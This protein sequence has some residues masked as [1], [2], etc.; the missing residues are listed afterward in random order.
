MKT[1]KYESKWGYVTVVLCMLI[2]LHAIPA[3]AE[4]SSSITTLH[5]FNGS[6]GKLPGDYGGGLTVDQGVLYGT[7]FLGGLNDAGVVFKINPDGSGFSILHTFA[8]TGVANDGSYPEDCRLAVGGGY[9]YGMTSAGGE[10]GS[11][12]IYKMRTDGSEYAVLK[13]FDSSGAAGGSPY[14]ALTLSGDVLYGMTNEGGENGAG[15]LFRIGTDGSDF[16]VLRSFVEQADGAGPH[17][18]VLVYNNALYGMNNYG[19]AESYGTIFKLGMDGSGFTVLHTFGDPNMVYDATYPYG[20]L[21]PV[22]DVLYG[23]SQGGHG[24]YVHVGDGAIFK[25]GADGTGYE[26]IHSFSRDDD[27]GVGPYGSLLYAGNMLYGM[28]C[29]RESD[30]HGTIFRVGLD[31]SDFTVLGDLGSDVYG[32]L[33]LSG[34]KL[35]GV[36][37]SAGQ[38]GYGT[39][40]SFPLP[41]FSSIEDNMGSMGLDFTDEEIGMLTEL[42]LDGKSGLNPDSLKIDNITWKYFDYELDGWLPGQAG[43]Y[44]ANYV[45][46]FGS[47]LLGEPGSG[48][49]P[50]PST[51][52]LLL[53]LVGFGLKKL[54]RTAK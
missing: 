6:D 31:G 37:S 15:T 44:G 11:G 23:M 39:I 19:G 22:G 24:I 30:L 10:N 17:G 13:S 2:G 21:T 51:L 49:V 45:F 32:D 14:G 46:Y 18:D 40:F 29:Y 53:P 9:F 36:T 48:D 7:T 33:I 4:T 28:T 52:L 3:F 34:G 42:Y 16:T 41:E 20:S 8:D 25:I 50:E 35:Y 5:E 47:G 12:I 1:F 43:K 27:A 54:R 38:Y 26:I